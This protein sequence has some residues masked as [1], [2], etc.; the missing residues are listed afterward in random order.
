MRG[1]TRTTPGGEA[2]LVSTLPVDFYRPLYPLGI[3]IYDNRHWSRLCS[4]A[5]SERTPL[6]IS[7][8][9]TK[10]GIFAVVTAAPPRPRAQPAKSAG[11]SRSTVVFVILI[12]VIVL[13]VI[14]FIV[15][16]RARRL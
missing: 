2:S 4:L 8:F 10:L 9:T 14:V 13:S 6:T 16:R 5:Q 12:V 7:C 1:S 15:V 3:Y 11:S